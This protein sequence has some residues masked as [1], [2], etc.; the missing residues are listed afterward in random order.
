MLSTIPA[1]LALS[2]SAFFAG[3]APVDPDAPAS[4]ESA[5][6]LG[7]GPGGYQAMMQSIHCHPSAGSG[8]VHNDCLAAVE[9]MHKDSTTAIPTVMFR[10][11]SHDLDSQLPQYYWHGTCAFLVKATRSGVTVRSNYATI[12][13]GMAT[14]GAMCDERDG[15]IGGEIQ[16][17]GLSIILLNPTTATPAI[18]RGWEFYVRAVTGIE[19]PPGATADEYARLVAGSSAAA[20]KAN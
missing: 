10:A 6:Q 8:I 18:R 5:V 3:A 19:V 9:K 1:I 17:G 13:Q 2:F 11:N 20:S 4:F 14:L 7:L 15:G 16:A 12:L